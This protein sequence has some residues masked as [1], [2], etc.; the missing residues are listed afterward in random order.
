MEVSTKEKVIGS[1][2][3]NGSVKK[4]KDVIENVV[5]LAIVFAL[6]Y[7]AF[8]YFDLADVQSF[9]ARFGVLAPLMFVLSKAATI[10]FAPL[11]GAALYPVA[12]AVFGFWQ[13][14]TVLMIGDA[15][16]GTIAFYISR[17]YGIRIAS[18]FIKEENVL[19]QKILTKLGSLR[20]YIF[21]RVCFS[22]MPEVVCYAAGLTKMSY[23]QFILVHVI[24]GLPLTVVLVSAGVFFTFDPSPLAIS[25]MVIVGTIATL[26][27]GAWFYKQTK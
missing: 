18:R 4:Y 22:P 27:G 24:V 26:A 23:L 20:G 16:G 12:G 2:P 8:T 17:H 3:I 14:L 5:S 25:A 15:L 7:I 1:I 11:S 21:A 13:G 6:I 10:V 9:V 19:M